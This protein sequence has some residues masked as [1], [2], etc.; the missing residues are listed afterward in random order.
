MSFT[1]FKPDITAYKS[2]I[3]R[4]FKRSRLRSGVDGQ[5]TVFLIEMHFNSTRLEPYTDCY[6]NLKFHCLFLSPFP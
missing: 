4:D 6:E 1:G 3:L 5:P 2:G